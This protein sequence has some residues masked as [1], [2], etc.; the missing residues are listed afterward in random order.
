[1]AFGQ[2]A[3]F[4]AYLP[5]AVQRLEVMKL[6]AHALILG[7]GDDAIWKALSR[8][9]HSF[10]FAAWDEAHH[11]V[12]LH[13]LRWTGG[14]KPSCTDNGIHGWITCH[15]DAGTGAPLPLPK[16]DGSIQMRVHV[17]RSCPCRTRHWHP[18]KYGGTPPPARH[19]TVLRFCAAEEVMQLSFY[20]KMTNHRCAHLP[21]C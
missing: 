19:G 1:M 3:G 20:H 11:L 7:E 8:H 10:I 6:P 13:Q 9:E 5:T 2:G 15:Q 16:V 12:S 17:C 18:S 4:C 14:R 21:L